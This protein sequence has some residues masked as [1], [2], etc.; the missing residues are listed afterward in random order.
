MFVNSQKKSGS[1]NALIAQVSQ[2]NPPTKTP[3][4]NQITEIPA[5]LTFL[6]SN[7]SNLFTPKSVLIF[8]DSGVSICIV[9]TKHLP[10]FGIDKRN[11]VPCTKH[12]TVIGGSKLSCHRFI[13]TK[14]DIGHHT[15]KLPHICDKVDKIR[16][17]CTDTNIIPESFPYPMTN[18]ST[19]SISSITTSTHEPP[20]VKPANLPYPPTEDNVPLLEQYLLKQFNNSAFNKSSPFPSMSTKPAHIH[21][22]LDAKPYAHHVTIPISFHWKAEVKEST[23]RD[24]AINITEPVPIREPVEWCSKI[25]VIT[26]KDG[27]PR[28]TVDLQ[29]LNSQCQRGNSS[30]SIAISTCLPSSHQC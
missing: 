26:K 7:N 22:H 10:D 3:Q 28:R 14:F 9:G 30:L 25:I 6:S 16:Q 4:S 2:L 1:A 5:Q 19:T 8:P 11:L 27:R 29:Q 24:I 13:S 23:N 18:A 20:P 12:I 15:T 17:G 21:L